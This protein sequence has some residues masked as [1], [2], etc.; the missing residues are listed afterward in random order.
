MA[1]DLDDAD[2][3]WAEFLTHAN[4]VYTKLRAACHGQPL[5]WMWWKKKMDERRDDPLLC[6]IHHARNCDTH[7]LE[8][9]TQHVESASVMVK[10]PAGR[11][12]LYG[13]AHLRP[14]PVI[15]KCV[16]YYPPTKH[17]GYNLAEY[18]ECAL[19]THLAE[20]HLQGLVAE[21]ASRLR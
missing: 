4:R 7:R 17:K 1:L 15:D 19:I 13:P 18:V 3:A 11:D 9:M 8:P 10:D 2:E 21:A 5:D 16:T 6:Y 14:L 20:L 12:A